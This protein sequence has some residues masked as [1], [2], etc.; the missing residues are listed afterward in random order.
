MQAESAIQKRDYAAAEPL[1]A[2][3]VKD[4]P[5]NYEAWFDLGFTE[6]VLGKVDESIAAYRKSVAVKPDVF[7]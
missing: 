2:K 5:A 6:N 4:D 1:L 7:E 3:V